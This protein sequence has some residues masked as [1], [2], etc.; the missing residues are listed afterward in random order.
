MEAAID[1]FRQIAAS[2]A[3]FLLCGTLPSACGREEVEMNASPD[4]QK[5]QL[6]AN[7]WASSIGARHRPLGANGELSFG[8]NGVRYDPA[9]NAMLGRIWIN[10]APMSAEHPER[11][12]TYRRMLAALNDP[13]IGGMFDRS[14][15]YFSLDEKAQGFYLVRGFDLSSGTPQSFVTEMGRM[16]RVGEKWTTQWFLDVAMIMHGKERAPRSQMRLED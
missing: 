1:R 6:F 15:G 13:A 16:Q 5:A 10:M 14:G 8:D 7:A 2:V 9:T 12:E 11:L 4:L 3:V